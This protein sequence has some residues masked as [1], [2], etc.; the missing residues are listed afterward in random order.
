MARKS[1][2]FTLVE[3]LVVIAIIGI[4]A[5]MLLPTLGRA[6]EEARKAKCK[7]NLRQIGLGIQMYTND[8]ND[9]MPVDIEEG[10]ARGETDPMASLAL[11]YPE[12]VS[13]RM[14]FKCPS[15]QD[16][17][18]EMSDGDDFSPQP[19]QGETG[20]GGKVCS[21]GYD[22]T[23]DMLNA[24]NTSEIALLADAP[25]RTAAG[26]EPDQNSPNHQNKGQNVCFMDGHIE[27]TNNPQCGLDG[28]NIFGS[29]EMMPAASDSRVVQVNDLAGGGGGGGGGGS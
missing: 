19:P 22:D 20:G 7:S 25:L 5:S 10:I 29:E 21:Y 8:F 3:L 24:A 28:D 17:L 23:K 1:R 27:W 14:V 26:S 13:S 12:Y 2:G 11:L 16:D 4:L 6:R 9:Y 15:S 18:S